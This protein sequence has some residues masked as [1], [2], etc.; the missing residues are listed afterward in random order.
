MKKP[1]TKNA[2]IIDLLI[3][4]LLV[5]TS[6]ALRIPGY[7]EQTVQ[8]DEL[9]YLFYA[10]S[11]LANNWS[12]PVEFMWA[13]PPLYSY[14]NAVLTS[15]FGGGLEVFRVVPMFFGVL[16]VGVIYLLGK[17][18]YNR[19]VGVLAGGFLSF[20]VF[21]ILYSRTIMIEAMV[22][23]L[24]YT[25][26]LLF[27]KSYREDDTRYAALSGLF[28]GLALDTKFI[29]AFVYIGY[30][31]FL[32]WTKRKR[33]LVL[34]W[35]SLVERKFLIITSIS[36]L[37]FLPVFMD[38]Y[39][40]GVNPVYWQLFGRF[41][42]Q[43]AFYKGAGSFGLHNL[44]MGGVNNYINLLTGASITG[45]SL[46]WL[47]LFRM[48]SFVILLSTLPYFAHRFLVSEQS[49]S[50]LLSF[51]VPINIFVALYSVRF[52]YYLLWGLPAFFIMVSIMIVDLAKQFRGK[53]FRHEKFLF[54]DFIKLLILL[55]SFLLIS[56]SIV[57]GALFHSN[58]EPPKSGYDKQVLNLRNAIESGD[59]IAASDPAIIM[60]YFDRYGIDADI[61]FPVFSLYTVSPYAGT[62]R[63]VLDFELLQTLE[64][65]F[66]IVSK[67]TYAAY[68][69]IPENI[70]IRENYDLIA[71]ETQVLLFEKKESS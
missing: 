9:Y 46:A 59:N 70:F 60:Y 2:G 17:S 29:A 64:P 14:L 5:I 33:G 4:V 13:Q 68:V 18:L 57:G 28:L 39:L 44:V 48:A 1:L 6:F 22:M 3:V 7:V 63:R 56:F 20:N 61:E 12:W 30:V 24:M 52:D 66:L 51:Y 67:R 16:G 58:V 25:S 21:H 42:T 8:P 19:W 65:R 15:L 71:E 35:D 27:L 37:L 32:L 11:I 36:F 54:L 23:F 31:I 50:F 45:V 69:N 26:M 53:I 41:E 47:P 62:K 40:S 34:G 55:S 38:S 10:Y 43:R 49:G